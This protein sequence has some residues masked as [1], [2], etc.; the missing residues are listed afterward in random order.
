MEW[1]HENIRS[2]TSIIFTLDIGPLPQCAAVIED[3]KKTAGDIW[4]ELKHLFTTKN[5]QTI[6]NLSKKPY[7]LL[8][9]DGQN[10]EKHPQYFYTILGKND[11]PSKLLP[12]V[13]VTLA[14]IWKTADMN[15]QQLINALEAE[16]AGKKNRHSDKITCKYQQLCCRPKAKLQQLTQFSKKKNMNNKNIS[17]RFVCNKMS[18]YA[19]DFWYKQDGNNNRGGY[20]ERNRGR[21]LGSHPFPR[22]GALR[23]YPDTKYGER[24]FKPSKH[25]GNPPQS[26]KNP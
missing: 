9:K 6:I 2:H 22:R 26:V 8:Q 1:K 25:L 12:D 21:G 7:Y 19:K 23:G 15:L 24:N 20:R 18:H 17:P 14:M 10:W 16:L 11:K 3:K 13:F 4:I 5:T